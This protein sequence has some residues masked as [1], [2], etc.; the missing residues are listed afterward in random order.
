M[1]A[2]FMDYILI[3]KPIKNLYLRL[4]AEGQ[5]VVTAP[6]SLS[7]EKIEAF[8]QSREGLAKKWQL[9]RELVPCIP[10]DGDTV[11]L[12]GKP[13]ALGPGEDAA[14]W[15][16]RYRQETDRAARMLLPQWERALG[17]HASKLCV[18]KMRS[19]WGSC[20]TQTGEVHLSL[21]LAAFP[22]ET[23][24]GVLVHELCHLLHRGHDRAFY[25]CLEA[26]LPDWRARKALL[27]AYRVGGE[28]V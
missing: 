26:V 9:R 13:R 22:P 24:E 14:F 18:R 3:R 17:V 12:W 7:R 4:N 6:R 23:L 28:D 27:A 16:E 10:I 8:V 15:V 25:T 1:G 2:D 5:L 20:Q 19:R 11:H 21:Y